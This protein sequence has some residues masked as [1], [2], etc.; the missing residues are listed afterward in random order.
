M[1]RIIKK[2]QKGLEFFCIAWYKSIKRKQEFV[3]GIKE[4][5]VKKGKCRYTLLILETKTGQTKI[6]LGRHVNRLDY[7]YITLN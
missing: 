4:I 1:K 7:G 6:N 3:M 2:I 5:S